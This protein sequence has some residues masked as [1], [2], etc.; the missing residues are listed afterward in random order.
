MR[1]FE[2][3]KTF[4]GEVDKAVETVRISAIITGDLVDKQ[5]GKSIQ[6][7]DFFDIKADIEALI[8]MTG[9]AG[10]F[11]FVTTDHAA[12]QPGQAARIMRDDEVVGIVGKLHPNITKQF[13]IEKA[14]LV[15]ELDADACFAAVVPVARTIS[16]FPVIRRDIAV[17]V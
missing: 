10:D 17:I 6:S 14:A 13:D 9:A 12:L 1:I 16:R 2:I 8:T 3:G 5:W 15:F 11:S 7:V 4:H